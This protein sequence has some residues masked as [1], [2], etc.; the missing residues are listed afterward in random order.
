MYIVDPTHEGRVEVKI[1]TEERTVTY[2]IPRASGIH[3]DADY[4]PPPKEYYYQDIL[5]H[6]FPVIQNLSFKMRPIKNDDP[7]IDLARCI[8]K[9]HDD[10]CI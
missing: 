5:V 3:L 8:I 1:I 7:A 9:R 4:K 6:E 2:I 10:Y